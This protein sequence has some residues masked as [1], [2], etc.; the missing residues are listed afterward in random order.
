MYLGQHCSTVRIKAM[1]KPANSCF[2]ELVSASNA[3]RVPYTD[4][5]ERTSRLVDPM[6]LPSGL[7]F[8]DPRNMTG[9]H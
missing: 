5:A 6:Y 8:K 3:T 1:F 4:L 9:C 7:K 2:S